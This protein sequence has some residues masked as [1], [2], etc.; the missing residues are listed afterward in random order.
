MSA[1]F[2]DAGMVRRPFRLLVTPT[3]Y[4]AFAAA[5]AVVAA[6]AAPRRD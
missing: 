2:D 3:V 1:L 4:A 5:A 6:A